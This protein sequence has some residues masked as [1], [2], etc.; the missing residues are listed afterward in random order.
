M[1]DTNHF[2]CKNISNRSQICGDEFGICG[3]I[4]GGVEGINKEVVNTFLMTSTRSDNCPGS[5]TPTHTGPTACALSNPPVNHNKS[6][7]LFAEI[8]C[9]AD[10]FKCC[11][12]LYKSQKNYKQ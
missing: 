3:A 7:R 11:I 9:R 10:T 8:I 5:L 2:R 6:Y 1:V 4:I 12:E